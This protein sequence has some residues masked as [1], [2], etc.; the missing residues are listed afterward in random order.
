MS[1]P[2]FYDLLRRPDHETELLI[3]FSHRFDL[4]PSPFFAW[5][6]AT[7]PAEPQF[8]AQPDTGSRMW[9]SGDYKDWE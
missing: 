2:G 9:Q 5:R 7:R 6:S 1:V 8:G 3:V 4:C